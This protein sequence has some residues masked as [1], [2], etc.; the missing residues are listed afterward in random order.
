[1]PATRDRAMAASIASYAFSAPTPRRPSQRSRPPWVATQDARACTSTAPL[2]IIVMSR[3]NRL[4]PC[5]GTPSR[6]E[7]AI[8]RAH[9]SARS[10]TRPVAASAR[11]NADLLRALYHGVR[12]DAED[13]DGGQR[14]RDRGKDSEQ[15][16][17]QAVHG[18]RLRLQVVDRLD[19]L[20]HL[21]LVDARDRVA[22]RAFHPRG[23]ERR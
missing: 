5:E 9:K 4:R 8:S 23:I 19:A 20:D 16:R 15:A 10:G 12:D 18:P 17:A 14:E 1:M 11:A 22:K 13:P 7:S 6:V 3:G 2:R 21:P